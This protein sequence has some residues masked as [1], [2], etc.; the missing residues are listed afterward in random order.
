M[1]ERP[2]PPILVIHGENDL[3]VPPSHAREFVERMR[4][5]S[6]HPTVY[7]ELP[8]GHHDFDLYESIRSN[9]VSIS[10]ERFIM[11]G[12]RRNCLRLLL[13]RL[14]LVQKAAY[15]RLVPTV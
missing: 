2:Q 9:A 1:P 6:S 8:G 12:L 13:G 5:R 15:R 11:S 14:Y 4:V 3:P 10:I 7:V